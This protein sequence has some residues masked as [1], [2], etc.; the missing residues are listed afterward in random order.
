M[1]KRSTVDACPPAIFA[2]GRGKARDSFGK[3]SH[4]NSR[5]TSHASDTTFSVSPYM[6][7]GTET[8]WFF[9]LYFVAIRSEK[10]EKECQRSTTKT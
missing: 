9:L 6:G 7:N 4:C 2:S 1:Q 10:E 8:G 3:N 5:Y